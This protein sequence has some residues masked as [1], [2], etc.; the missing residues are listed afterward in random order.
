MG[1]LGFGGKNKARR[2]PTIARISRDRTKRRGFDGH[3]LL[4]AC[5]GYVIVCSPPLSDWLFNESEHRPLQ[6]EVYS[7]SRNCQMVVLA[8]VS[9]VIHEAAAGPIIGLRARLNSF[10]ERLLT[11]GDMP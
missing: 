8:A 10:G 11:G 1:L 6:G 3:F 7:D 5:D 4:E 2:K 9:I